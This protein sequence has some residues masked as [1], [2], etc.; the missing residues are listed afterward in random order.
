[1]TI[2]NYDLGLLKVYLHVVLREWIMTG[3]SIIIH[4]WNI[5]KRII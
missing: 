5:C 3:F 1:L 2:S 4:S